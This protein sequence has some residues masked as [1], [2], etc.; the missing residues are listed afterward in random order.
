MNRTETIVTIL[1]VLAVTSA[2]VAWYR[3]EHPP[4]ASKTE[5]IK[6]PQIKTVT[7]IKRITVPVEKVVT[8]EK[9]V[10]VEKLKLPPE[11][12][13]DDNKQ[14]ISTGEVVPYEGKT[15]VVA[16]LDTKT[17]ESQIIAKQAPLPFF[18]FVNK[19]EIGLRY[20]YGS[21][22]KVSMET[23]I[24]GRWDFLRIGNV[25]LGVYGEVNTNGE[26]R[27]MISAGYRW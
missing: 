2:V 18:D 16:V 6:V 4:V 21:A 25:H 5:Y 24:Y 11:I 14:V 17:G 27:A 23:D 13:Q 7:K 10:V 19:R 15:N 8:I 12:A 22:S 26:G 3:G 20:G 9:Q 1:A